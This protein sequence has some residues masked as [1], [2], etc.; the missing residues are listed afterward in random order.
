MHQIRCHK[1]K[2]TMASLNVEQV[3]EMLAIGECS[4]QDVHV[5]QVHEV[6]SMSECSSPAGSSVSK[7]WC[8]KCDR[9][10]KSAS[11]LR[12]HRNAKHPES[13]SSKN[14]PSI[15]HS[16]SSD[17][18]VLESP[19]APAIVTEEV[20]KTPSRPNDGQ[21]STRSGQRGALTKKRDRRWELEQ[22]VENLQKKWSL[23]EPI[24]ADEDP[25]LIQ[26]TDYHD[27]L[28]KRVSNVLTE[29]LSD[30]V[31]DVI[32]D[33]SLIDTDNRGDFNWSEQDRQRLEDFNEYV[34]QM[35][36][37]S[38]WTWAAPEGSDCYNFNHERMQ[39]CV[40]DECAF[41]LVP[42]CTEC[43]SSGLLVGLDQTCQRDTCY[44]C[45]AHCCGHHQSSTV[46]VVP[47][48]ESSRFREHDCEQRAASFY[49]C[50]LTRRN[51]RLTNW[52]K[53]GVT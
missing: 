18:R 12:L 37:P 36:V 17:D 16:T 15:V 33:P 48:P 7:A 53:R 24:V 26:L 50:L 52:Q 19:V 32:R 20:F 23:K 22:L 6:K 3:D 10:F 51:V 43:S 35:Q 25:R 27:S 49:A 47:L 29:K 40:R 14:L 28:L 9:T 39:M 46:V 44:D 31:R 34:N 4:S 2:D 1:D 8:L 13:V 5:E 41:T 45:A 38:R 42:S 30:E 21:C 11:G